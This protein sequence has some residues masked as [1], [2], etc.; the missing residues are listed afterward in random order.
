MTWLR[1]LVS[2]LRAVLLVG[3]L[4][5]DL[6]DEI[7]SHLDFAARENE[8]RGMSPEQARAEAL[9]QF[10]GVQWIKERYRDRRGLPMLESV[11]QDFKYAVRGFR[12]SPGFTVVVLLTLAL[13][14]GANTAIFSLINA[15]LLRPLPVRQPASLVQLGTVGPFGTIA[16][17]SYSDFNRFRDENQVLSGL[18]ASATLYGMEAEIDG[19]SAP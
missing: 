14:I 19:N 1:T 13:G 16:N 6:D 10:G 8:R 4:E 17:F 3:K 15:L 7:R 18:L 9:R 2:R 11:V 5:G 12:R